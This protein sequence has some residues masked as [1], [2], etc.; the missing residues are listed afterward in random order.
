MTRADHK[1]GIFPDTGEV[2]RDAEF[3]APRRS[4][5][6][7]HLQQERRS[8]CAEQDHY[9]E[10]GIMELNSHTCRWPIVKIGSE[11]FRYCGNRTVQG[12]PYCIIH[13]QKAYQPN[14]QKWRH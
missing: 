12:K 10:L 7:G 5:A 8:G 6:S 1:A 13:C 9:P 2:A 11:D 14:V 3:I 4:L